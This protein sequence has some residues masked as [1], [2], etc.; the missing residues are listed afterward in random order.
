MADREI[1]LGAT[2][3]AQSAI[4]FE[5]PQIENDTTDA[6]AEGHISRH[7]FSLPPVDGGRDAWLFLTAC[8]FIEALVWGESVT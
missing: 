6:D 4:H 1:E 5:N 2:P 8:F 7:E 3:T